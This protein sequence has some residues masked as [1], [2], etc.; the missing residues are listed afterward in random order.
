[1]R[2]IVQNG[3]LLCLICLFNHSTFASAIEGLPSIN[4]GVPFFYYNDLQKAADW[5]EHKLGLKKV[6]HKEWV[7]IF[8]LTPTSQIGLVNASGGSLEPTDNK[9]ALL[10]IET[11]ELEAWY[12]RLKSVE[13]INM[14]HGIEI[15]A[16]GM[17]EEFR[18]TD[19]GGYVI[20]FFR[21]KLAPDERMTG[22]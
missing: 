16:G 3:L 9:G 21:W 7:I 10:S 12:E 17:I 1:M 8:E 18:M 6:A 4:A 11:N 15:G 13:G 14:I 5:Y 22:S 20:E 2:K 19:P